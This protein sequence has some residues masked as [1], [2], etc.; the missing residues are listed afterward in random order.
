MPKVIDYGMVI[1]VNFNKNLEAKNQS[2]KPKEPVKTDEKITCYVIM[3]KF[4]MNV[5]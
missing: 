1:I 5:E 2:K 3:D 4:E